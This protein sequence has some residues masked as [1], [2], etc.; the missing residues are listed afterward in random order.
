MG[1]EDMGHTR[2]FYGCKW[3]VFQVIR[4]LAKVNCIWT[5]LHLFKD[6]FDVRG[7]DFK[8]DRQ[9]ATCQI[10]YSI[11]AVHMLQGRRKKV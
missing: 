5:N 2:L 7:A 6:R 11:V 10:V 9:S 8:S 3:S 1:Q 4:T